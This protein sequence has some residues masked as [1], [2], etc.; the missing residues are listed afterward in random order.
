MPRS[1]IDG[2]VDPGGVAPRAAVDPLV[3]MLVVSVQ[4][5]VARFGSENVGAGAPRQEVFAVAATE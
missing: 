5:V 2:S 4:S 1:R 3:A